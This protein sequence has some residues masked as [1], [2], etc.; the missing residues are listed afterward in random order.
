MNTIDESYKRLV[1][2]IESAA[3]RG[4]DP[5]DGLMSPIFQSSILKNQKKIRFLAQQFVKRFPINLRPALGIAPGYNPVTLG[6]CLQGYAT[7]YKIRQEEHLL[8]KIN[9]LISEL[10]KLIPNGF[11]GACWGY[12]FDWEARYARIPGYQ[13]T[14]VATGIIT[15]AL[16]IAYQNCKIEKAKE[17]LLSAAN[18]TINDLNRSYDEDKN[19]CFSY[20]PFDH[21]IVFNAS[22]KGARLLSQAYFLNA[23]IHYAD[24]AELAVKFVMNHQRADGA[25]VYSKSEVGGWID[26]YH[27]GYVLDCLAAYNS[28]C[29][30]EKFG[31][32]YKKG[33][34]YY[35]NNFFLA[36]GQPKFYDQ[37]AFPIDCTA[38]AQSILTLS[39]NGANDTA[40]KV[41]QFM[42]N[43]M[44]HKKGYFYF[45]KFKYY[46]IKTSYMRW[47]NAWMMASL[48]NLLQK[49]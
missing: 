7:D 18:F 9:L 30:N 42:I 29:S 41:A 24:T 21:Q 4:H 17:L 3:Y 46:T 47:S 43:T 15:N 49:D 6:L 2:Y 26:N 27:T 45:R 16:F 12:D 25:W 37:E 40:K 5:Y 11:S 22:M 31:E 44:Q 28:Y 34:Q 38:A 10:E 39:S 33:F 14:I 19:I 32:A 1:G 48:S 35:L 36:N 23:N 20:S 13:P 8:I